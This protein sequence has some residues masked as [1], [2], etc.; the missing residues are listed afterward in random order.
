MTLKTVKNIK[1]DVAK[2]ENQVSH[3]HIQN[4]ADTKVSAVFW[5]K[6]VDTARKAQ[7]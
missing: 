5:W 2:R 6:G 7:D 3:T 1:F 4:T